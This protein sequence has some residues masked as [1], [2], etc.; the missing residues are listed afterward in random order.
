MARTSGQGGRCENR[1]AEAAPRPS[2]CRLPSAGRSPWRRSAP[3]ACRLRGRRPLQ[4]VPVREEAAHQG[5][6]DGIAHAPGLI[7]QKYEGQSGLDRRQLHLG[8]ERVG[9]GCRA[10]CRRG[11]G[12][13]RRT[14]R[15]TPAMPVRRGRTTVPTSAEGMGSSQVSPSVEKQRRREQRPPQIVEDLAE[16]DGAVTACLSVRQPKYPGQ[17]LPVAARPAVLALGGDVVTGREF[18]DHLDIGGKT[19]ARE[20]AFEEVVAQQRV[21]RDAAG[22]GRFEGVDIIDALAGIRTFAE[23]VLIDVGDRGR[24]G[25][26]ARP[27]RENALIER[28]FAARPAATASPAV[29]ECRSRRRRAAGRH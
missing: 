14:A 3:A 15:K 29:A 9:N 24:I 25:I 12:K 7:G 6:Q 21:L 16:P 27:A 1:G 11:A 17:Q 26:D 10:G 23:Q 19:G 18:V 28:A 5:P 20:D 8:A 4:Q 13:W 22:Q 2:P